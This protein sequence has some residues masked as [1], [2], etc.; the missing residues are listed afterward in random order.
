MVIEIYLFFLKT[1]NNTDHHP[2]CFLRPVRETCSVAL[3]CA[4]LSVCGWGVW[5]CASQEALKGMNAT[6]TATR[7]AKISTECLL[8]CYTLTH[9]QGQTSFF[10]LSLLSSKI[11]IVSS[12]ASFL[13]SRRYL[14][15]L[16]I[17]SGTNEPI[18]VIYL[19][20]YLNKS[21]V[22]PASTTFIPASR[23][24]HFFKESQLYK[25]SK[26]PD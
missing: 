11:Q 16:L 6:L 20:D 21:T 15:G 23:S 1:Q 25:G 13:K 8:S 10:S 22:N 19:F 4:A 5:G 14:Q 7:W 26:M 24:N 9:S 3:V 17:F 12:A 2:V 18:R